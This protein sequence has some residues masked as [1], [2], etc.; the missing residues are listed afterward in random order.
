MKDA[1]GN[2]LLF[3]KL[4]L[5]APKVE[6]GRVKTWSFQVVDN[7][8]SFTMQITPSKD[9]AI[10]SIYIAALTDGGVPG[11]LD[12]V[13]SRNI[14]IEPTS[15]SAADISETPQGLVYGVGVSENPTLTYTFGESSL[16]IP[17][18]LVLRAANAYDIFFGVSGVVLGAVNTVRVIIEYWDY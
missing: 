18:N 17:I 5:K 10:K 12:P 14:V 3:D 2:S 7:A 11:N 8:T 15:G 9:M 4:K 16:P 6:F 1:D 13:V